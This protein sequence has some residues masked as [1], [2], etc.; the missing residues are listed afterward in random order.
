MASRLNP[1]IRFDGTARE[2]LDL[3]AE[4]F[5]GSPEIMTFGE[6]GQADSPDAGKIMHGTLDTAAGYTIMASDAPSGMPAQTPGGS[7][8]VSLSG[9]DADAL[10]GYWNKLTVGGTVDMPLEKQFWGDEFGMCTDRFGV[11]WM[12]NISQ[13]QSRA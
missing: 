4:T 3:Y 9:D 1:Y 13:A 11:Q 5:G 12:V 8:A 6:A 10:R 7:I 2:A